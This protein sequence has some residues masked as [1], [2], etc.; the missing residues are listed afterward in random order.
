MKKTIL[1]TVVF[2]ALYSI[3]G[4][5]QSYKINKLNYDYKQY[6][7]KIGDPYNPMVSGLCSF[8]VPGLGQML[9]GES[10]RGL[11]FLAGYVGSVVLYGVGAAQD[12]G[13]EGQSGSGTMLLGAGGMLAIGIWSIVDAVKVAKVNNMYSWDKNKT[14]S[15]S[16]ELAPYVTQININNEIS[17]PVGLSLRLNF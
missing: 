9:S 10:G 6:T 8:F 11:G 1:L 4:S 7:P 14:S 12:L 13:T 3:N 15:I 17:T 16:L 5:A 2:L